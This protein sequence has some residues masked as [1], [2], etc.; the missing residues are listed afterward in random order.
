VPDHYV[1]KQTLVNA[2]RYI[3]DDLKTFESRV[4]NAEDQR[5]KL[6]LTIFLDIR[7]TV[8][9]HHREIQEMA[10]FIARID[11]LSTFAEVAHDN[12]YCRPELNTQG[13]LEINEGR[14][15][16]VEKLLAGER[17]VPNSIT[18]D[19]LTDQVLIITGPNMAGKSTVLRQVAL[20][21][22]MAQIG[23]FVP[24]QKACISITDRIFTR[25]GALDNLTA[26]QSTFMVEMQET[27]NIV[28]NATSNS[29]VILDEIGRGTSTFDGLSIAWA[30]AEH[31]HNVN[32]TGT[33][34]LFA[35]HYHELTELENQLDRVKNYNI[36]VKE[37]NDEIIFLRKLVN[38]GTNRSY[39]IQVARLAG[40]PESIIRRSKTILAQIESGTQPKVV[41]DQ[42]PEGHVQ[43]ALFSPMEKKLVETLQM[44]DLSRM[45]PID[46][47]NLLNELQIKAQTVVY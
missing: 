4:L 35:T 12:G 43:L 25:V 18:L 42:R 10:R 30:V 22:V 29:L 1:R 44:V 13:E 20:I 23:S 38:G 11:C 47:L 32:G 7:E 2:E 41:E 40:I 34:T 17:F 19:N 31:L 26:G 6:E 33:R 28:N 37:W 5:S 27:A 9:A 46:A 36:A 21:T 8:K 24:A 16:V 45:T 39:G 3:T 15:P 14:H